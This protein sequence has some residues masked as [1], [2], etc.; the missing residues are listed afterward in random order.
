MGLTGPTPLFY[1]SQTVILRTPG[2]VNLKIPGPATATYRKLPANRALR[3]QQVPLESYSNVHFFRDLY[4][5]YSITFWAI[6]D[7]SL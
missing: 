7:F 4:S 1:S 2:F 6:H 5:I 3:A